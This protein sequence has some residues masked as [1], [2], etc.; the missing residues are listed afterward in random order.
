MLVLLILRA[1]A[2][3]PGSPVIHAKTSTQYY[4]AAARV[5]DWSEL[6]SLL[7]CPCSAR[8]CDGVTWGSRHRPAGIQTDVLDSIVEHLPPLLHCLDFYSPGTPATPAVWEDPGSNLTISPWTAVFITTAALICSFGHRL[9]T[10]TAVLRST[11]PCIPLGSLNQVPASA[12]I[13]AGMSSL[14]THI[15]CAFH[16]GGACCILL[17]PI[18]L[19]TNYQH[20]HLPLDWTLNLTH[21]HHYL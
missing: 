8:W 21:P 11:Q 1:H 18:T 14:P 19:F 5:M 9:H 15:A 7:A 12:G 2:C 13:E 10:F 20:A 4:V 17:Y 6:S 16:S 3:N